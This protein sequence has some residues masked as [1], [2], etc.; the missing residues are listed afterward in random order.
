SAARGRR[1]S[2]PKPRGRLRIAHRTKGGFAPATLEG[3]AAQP[4]PLP[5]GEGVWGTRGRGGQGVRAASNARSLCSKRIWTW[6]L[7]PCSFAQDS[8]RFRSSPP[9]ADRQAATGR[10]YRPGS[11]QIEAPVRKLYSRPLRLNV[12]RSA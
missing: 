3:R 8:Q 11:C 10:A 2:W 6:A 4:P 7:S 5:L 12:R 1:S 9:P